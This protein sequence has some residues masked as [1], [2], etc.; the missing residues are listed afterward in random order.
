MISPYIKN[1]KKGFFTY[2]QFVEGVNE[3]NK[4]CKLRAKSVQ[5][6]LSNT[7]PATL[8]GQNEK[9]EA[10]VDTQGLDMSKTITMY[11]ILGISNKD[12]DGVLKI[13]MD[14]LPEEYKTDG[15]IDMSKFNSSDITYLKKVFGVM[16]PIAYEISKSVKTSENTVIN[17]G[18]S[19]IVLVLS[20][21]AI[22]TFTILLSKYSRVKYKKR[23]MRRGR[24]EITSRIQDIS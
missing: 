9:P 20:L 18:I 23:S 8:E 5:G 19:R 10:L 15:K 21:I 1:D 22:I 7:V 16:G 12:M 3:L 17:H 2:D 4:F 14:Y 24:F 6:Q 11:S 13:L